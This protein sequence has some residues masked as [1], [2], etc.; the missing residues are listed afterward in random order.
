MNFCECN[1]PLC[2]KLHSKLRLPNNI[3]G[4]PSYTICSYNLGCVHFNTDKKDRNIT[5]S[6]HCKDRCHGNGKEKC[7]DTCLNCIIKFLPDDTTNETKLTFMY[8]LE[9]LENNILISYLS[10]HNF[11]YE[12]YHANIK[13]LQEANKN[14]YLM[15]LKIK[16]K[17]EELNQ[18]DDEAK[19][20][21]SKI[22]KLKL[23]GTKSE[24]LLLQLIMCSLNK[25]GRA[26][27]V[28]PDS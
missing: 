27:L 15:D 1:I 20:N 22:K 5:S 24:P 4:N 16:K 11:K 6:R 14:L 8:D 18:M 23:R 19:D 17:N 3:L 12:S 21:L 7:S 13:K 10:N 28:V 2:L 26:V 9:L 25:N